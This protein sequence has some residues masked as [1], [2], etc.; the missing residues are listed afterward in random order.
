MRSTN[1][2]QNRKGVFLIPKDDFKKPQTLSI[3]LICSI[4]LILLT[5]GMIN[6]YSASLQSSYFFH[7][8]RNLIVIIPAFL[9]FAFLVPIRKV[10]SYAYWVYGFTCLMLF[11]VLILG[12][13]AGGAQRWLPIGPFSFQ[14]SEFAK[15]T[16]AI[17]V[18]RFF[19]FHRLN[20]PYRIRDTFPLIVMIIVIFV[21]IFTQPDFGTAGI[22]VLIAC[23][24]VAFIRIDLRSIALV[25]VS[26]PIVAVVG[27]TT[28]LKEYQKLRIL[29]LFNP[30]LDP[31]NTGYNSLQ[32]L[33]AVG[34]GNLFGKGF[35]QGT[36]TQLRFLPERHTDFIF[37][38][39]A[40]E[41]GF[42]GGAIIFGLFAILAYVAL[43]IAK[44]AKDTFSGLLAIG[45]S[46]FIFFE[47]AINIAMV[48][49]IF[50]VVGLPLPFFSYG[51]SSLLTVCVA[52]GLLVSI[53][54]ASY[55]K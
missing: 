33:I 29:N 32:S 10:N 36:Q 40:E 37:S 3:T 2:G 19:H 49:G 26:S 30:N 46:A 51:S 20:T 50:P 45:I 54:R 9:I 48:L 12:R 16:T 55:V 8:L 14:P 13:M 23:A 35:M 22:C 24:Q 17:I 18:A 11:V 15:I 7:Q 21:L 6:L 43:D 28:L 53:N 1:S 5:L 41:Q 44:N 31:Q 47:F 25:L 34:S 38:V 42:W 4:F 39:F 27:W 52:L